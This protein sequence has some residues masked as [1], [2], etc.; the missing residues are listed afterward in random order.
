MVFTVTAMNADSCYAS[1]TA[2]VFVNK[3]QV[4]FIPTVFTPNNDGLNDRFQ[5]AILGASNIDV[6]IYNRWGES[7]F[8]NTN[9]TNSTTAT[10]GWDGTYN[11]KQAPTDTYVYKMAVTYFDGTTQN[12]T[13][14]I[15]LM[16]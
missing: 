1:D 4:S 5:F 8:H 10:D 13:G 11:G 2:T 12:K 6:S 9:Q 15:T 3:E 7:V 16:R 14:T